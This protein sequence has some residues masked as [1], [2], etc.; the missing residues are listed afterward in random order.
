MQPRSSHSEQEALA[1]KLSRRQ[2]LAS[3]AMLPTS[4]IFQVRQEPKTVLVI[5]EFLPR[6]AAALTAGT[7]LLNGNDFALVEHSLAQFLPQLGELAKQPSEYQQEAARLACKGYQLVSILNLHRNELSL[8]EENDKRAIEYAR[9][10]DDAD[11][12][13]G[14]LH[15]LA[16]TFY[17]ADIP[18]KMLHTYQE[19]LQHAKE[20]SPVL[21]SR[22]SLGLAEAYA[23]CG[24]RQEADRALHVAKEQLASCSDFD[25]RLFYNL[26]GFTPYSLLNAEGSARLDMEQYQEAWNVFTSVDSLPSTLV[27]PERTRLEMLNH[28][29]EAALGMRDMEMFCACIKAGRDGAL[30]LGS[31]KRYQEVFEVYKQ[32]RRLWALEKRVRELGE[33]FIR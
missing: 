16:A 3:L 11:L 23:R 9:L 7:Q 18:T 29:A 10:A 24:K 28:Q 14:S 25:Q 12:L 19:A 1:W 21:R 17:H 8:R 31:E 33:L 6:S 5:E 32:G 13:A 26:A 22:I 27:I 4:L 30:A 2:A 15:R 20:I